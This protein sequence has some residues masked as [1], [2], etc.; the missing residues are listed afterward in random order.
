MM[1]WTSGPK[2]TL[3]RTASSLEDNTT[4]ETN[5]VTY[6]THRLSAARVIQASVVLV[7]FRLHIAR[8]FQMVESAKTR[9]DVTM[10]ALSVKQ[11][12]FK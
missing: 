4:K 9:V 8:P 3:V 7:T 6:H 11:T 1:G 12:A 2:G 10:N 5:I